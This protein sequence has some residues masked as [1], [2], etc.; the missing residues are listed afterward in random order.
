MIVILLLFSQVLNAQTTA[1]NSRLLLPRILANSG[2]MTA[3]MSL[4]ES[5]LF[6]PASSAHS[7]VYS[8]EGVYSFEQY[9][10][11][12]RAHNYTASILDTKNNDYAG[13]GVVYNKRVLDS[14]NSEWELKGIINKL[15][16]E[17]RL[18]TGVGASS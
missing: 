13:G 16:M 17:N 10:N 1:S 6:N 7:K 4:N 15:F 8:M 3:R 2:A 11:N 5:I 9:P 14:N 12:S 18:A